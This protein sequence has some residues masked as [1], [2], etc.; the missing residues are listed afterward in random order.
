LNESGRGTCVNSNGPS[1]SGPANS[2]CIPRMKNKTTTSSD[3]PPE[4]GLVATV[5][6]IKKVGVSNLC[7]IES[8]TITHIA[9]STSHYIRFVGGSDLR[10]A[11]T[12]K[13]ELLELSGH[14]INFSITESGEVDVSPYIGL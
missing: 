4:V 9:N 5:E 2:P 10:F 1:L 12:D 14:C 13:G 3:E 8:H 6:T 11:F 7:D